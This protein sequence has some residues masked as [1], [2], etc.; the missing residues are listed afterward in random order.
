MF[1]LIGNTPQYVLMGLISFVDFMF[2]KSSKIYIETKKKEYIPT[3]VRRVTFVQSIVLNER[4]CRLISGKS[5][6]NSMFF[7]I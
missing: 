4:K 3:M 6:T 7:V 1:Y 5:K 2:V